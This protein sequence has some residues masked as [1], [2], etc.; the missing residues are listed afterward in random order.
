MRYPKA[1]WEDTIRKAP[2]DDDDSMLDYL[3]SIV[4]LGSLGFKGPIIRRNLCSH[5]IGPIG[6]G[7][8]H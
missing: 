5:A 6:F 2:F 8:L 1:G 3:T 4:K 7:L